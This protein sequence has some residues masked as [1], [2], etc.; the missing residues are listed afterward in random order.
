MD[1]LAFATKVPAII[2]GAVEIIDHV[3]TSGAQKKIAVVQAIPSAIELAEFAA[4]RDLLH[5]PAIA[6]L[7]SAAVDAEAAA[8]KARKALQA[9]LLAKAPPSVP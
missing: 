7:V 4:G 2:K 5:D 6:L 1:W 9:G 3:K 8:L